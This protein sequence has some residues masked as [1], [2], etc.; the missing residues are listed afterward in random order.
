DGKIRFVEADALTPDDTRG[1]AAEIMNEKEFAAFEERGDAD[2]AYGVAGL[3]RFRVN[4]LRQRGSVGIVMRHVKGKI[5]EFAELNL[6]PALVRVAE[7]H[8]GLV[9]VTGT[10]GSGKS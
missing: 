5:L 2:L 10:T 1:F 7:M 3:G 6:P 8:R 4:I 9:L